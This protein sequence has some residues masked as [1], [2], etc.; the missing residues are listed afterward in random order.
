MECKDSF[1]VDHF[2]NGNFIVRLFLLIIHCFCSFCSWQSLVWE[3]LAISGLQCQTIMEKDKAHIGS[4]EKK[5]NE[6]RS[7]RLSN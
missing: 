3:D 1:I 7:F 2:L 6:A 5:R 4:V